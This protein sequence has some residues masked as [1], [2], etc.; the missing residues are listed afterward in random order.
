MAYLKMRRNISTGRAPELQGPCDCLS[1][2]HPLQHQQDSKIHLKGLRIS[3][4]IEE[5]LTTGQTVKTSP[6]FANAPFKKAYLLLHW[7]VG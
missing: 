3:V 4:T 7:H 5:T 2:P 1:H 6:P